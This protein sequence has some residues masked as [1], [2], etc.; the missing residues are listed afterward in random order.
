MGSARVGLRSRAS[1]LLA[2]AALSF[3]HASHAQPA[4]PTPV[5]TAA[6]PGASA[7]ELNPNSR[8]RP[9]PTRR[10]QDV[11]TPEPP[12]P[13]P[14][15]ASD[16]Q[17]TL[18]SVTFRGATALTTDDLRPTYAED[19]N[20]P[21]PIAVVCSI[22]D[23]AARMLFDRGILAR[24]E[25][26]EQRIAAG[27]LT[28]EVIEAHVV[29]V[30]VRGDIGPAQAAVERYV[31]RLRGM[32][33]FDMRRA[34]RYLLLA[35]DIPGVN[36][37]AAIRPSTSAERG[38]VDID[39]TV[40]RE[41]S[42]AIANV[43]NLGSKSVGRWGGLLRGEIDGLT[44]LAEASS[45]TA[46]R[47]IAANEQWLVSATEDARL[48]GDGW[49]VR[50]VATYGESHPGGSLLKPLGLKSTSVIG[51]VEG[52]YPLVRSRARN[53]NLA[54]GFDWIDTKANLGGGVPLS[55]DHL[56]VIYARADGDLR[57]E[58]VGYPT[59][60][61]GSIAVR[62]GVS[63]LGGSD[64]GSALLSRNGAKPAAWLVRGGGSAEAAIS[65][66]LVAAVRV[67][68]QYAGKPLLP[69]EQLS[70]GDLTVG[71][72][73][74]PSAVL[75]DSGVA[76]AVEL[77]YGA[78]QVYPRVLATPYAFFD[79]GRVHNNDAALSGLASNKTLKSVGGGVLFR[80]ANR[81]NLEF[82]VAHA[83]DATPGS[84]RKDTRV[85]VQ[86]TARLR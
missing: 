51:S 41:D 56:R 11:F 39:V 53:L 15:A 14:L 3:P 38:A 37:R 32:A 30:R 24:V 21:Q 77:R 76:G 50:G 26:P 22:R 78:L 61:N 16:V 27:A 62:K 28:L 55:R 58:L 18:G 65:G 69:Y 86:L 66:R 6:T 72:G 45:L 67:Q 5:Q 2:I 75:G 85:L 42:S 34:Q 46:F 64:S 1:L 63:G 17:V 4:P 68:G 57:T 12:G 79:A 74:D 73:Y 9:A 47:T 44:P 60:L 52:A 70:L 7:P 29:N 82:T 49:V 20:R 23:R 33:P 25:I 59:L 81:A 35:S 83:L 8:L 48:G 13:C 71:R 54:G 10:S 19:L 80:V 40:T 36:M 84:S 31:E 43:Q